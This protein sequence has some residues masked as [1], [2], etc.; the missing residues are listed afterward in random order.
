MDAPAN[1]RRTFAEA[2]QLAGAERAAYLDRARAR[3]PALH[4]E[5]ESLLG[6]YAQAGIQC[7]RAALEADL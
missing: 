4:E 6:A 7:R 1:A 3:D 5:T 2:L